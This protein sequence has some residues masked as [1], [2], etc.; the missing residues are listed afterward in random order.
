MMDPLV[1]EYKQSDKGVNL[2]NL[3][4]AETKAENLIDKAYKYTGYL[5]IAE[6]LIKMIVIPAATTLLPKL[7]I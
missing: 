6:V 5:A 2:K 7:L 4:I 3:K 1:D